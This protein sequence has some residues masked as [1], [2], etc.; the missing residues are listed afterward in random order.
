MVA[1]TVRALQVKRVRDCQEIAVAVT[2]LRVRAKPSGKN[3]LVALCDAD[4]H[5]LAAVCFQVLRD[6]Q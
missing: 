2:V 6:V 3:L 5:D 1:T 4:R